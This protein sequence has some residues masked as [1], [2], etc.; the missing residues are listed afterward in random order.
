MSNLTQKEGG[1]TWEAIGARP[2]FLR[3]V[4]AEGAH[5]GDVGNIHF[6]KLIPA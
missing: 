6:L 3:R 2:A 1:V 5:I 4:R